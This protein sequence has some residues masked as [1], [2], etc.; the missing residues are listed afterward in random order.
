MSMHAVHGPAAPASRGACTMQAHTREYARGLQYAR[1]AAPES[2]AA[3]TWALV[4]GAT[5]S[6]L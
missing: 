2:G 4:Q 1:P 6:R 3:C 5:G